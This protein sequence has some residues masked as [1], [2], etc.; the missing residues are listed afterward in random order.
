MKKKLDQPNKYSAIFKARLFRNGNIFNLELEDG[1][2]VY[3]YVDQNLFNYLNKAEIDL[4]NW[5][6][7][8][9]QYVTEQDKSDPN[10][11]ILKVVKLVALETNKKAQKYF[12]LVCYPFQIQNTQISKYG[13]QY[14]FILANM[15]KEGDKE[16]IKLCYTELTNPDIEYTEQGHPYLISTK[17]D[18]RPI[19]VTCYQKGMNLVIKNI[20]LL[21]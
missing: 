16:S 1:T 20:E 13:R 17:N 4:N 19:R 8:R 10:I 15:F 7:W 6:T 14:N 5:Y 12:S 18:R 9:G 2:I 3:T 21:Y 11:D